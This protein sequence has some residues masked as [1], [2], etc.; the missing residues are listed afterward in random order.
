MAHERFD[1][2]PLL[3]SSQ[4]LRPLL[5]LLTHKWCLSPSSHH[6]NLPLASLIILVAQELNKHPAV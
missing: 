6:L 4:W 5:Q 3:Q 1:N 2:L